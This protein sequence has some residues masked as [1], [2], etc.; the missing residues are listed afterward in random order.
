AVWSTVPTDSYASYSGTSMATP[1]VTG[2]TALYA[3]SHQAAK[4]LDIKNAILDSARATP[5][6]SLAGK[7]VTGGRLNLS[8]IIAPPPPAPSAPGGL[9][10][11]AVSSSQI[12]LAWTDNA[13][14][15]TGFKIERSNDGIN[16]I[17]IAAVGA[18]IL[19][20]SNAGL[21]SS[22][23]YYYQ[24]RAY[25]AGGNSE[26]SNTAS[27]TTLAPPVPPAAPSG[28]KAAAVSGSQIN[29]SWT[30]N[31][32][33]E[34]GF[35]IERKK[36]SGGIWSQIATVGAGITAYSNTGLS[37]RSTYYYRVRAYNSGGNSNYSNQ[38][39]AKTL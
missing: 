8:D 9:T 39:S 32:N 17:Q 34:D 36:G 13:D 27:A 11:T 5:T 37:R 7:T 19:S 6:S 2:A 16:F 4:A 14:N 31:S 23:A 26:F 20:Y 10:A 33:N 38:A 24:V 30:D 1:H 21:S 18:N 28:L 15:E 35:R 22:T 12:E 3:S 29:L 25:N